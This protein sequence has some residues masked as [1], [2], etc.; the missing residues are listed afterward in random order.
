MLEFY[1]GPLNTSP[2]KDS[3][4]LEVKIG[5]AFSGTIESNGSHYITG[6]LCD[7]DEVRQAFSRIRKSLDLAEN[8]ALAIL[9]ENKE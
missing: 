4:C 6:L 1:I 8:R 3:T 7:E 9:N 2:L 5:I